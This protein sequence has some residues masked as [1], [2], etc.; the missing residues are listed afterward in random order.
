VLVLRTLLRAYARLFNGGVPSSASVVTAARGGLGV[1]S[2]S[3]AA[4]WP[5]W[6]RYALRASRRFF[7]SSMSFSLAAKRRLIA[8]RS[9][10]AR[11]AR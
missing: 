8:A 4:P 9:F 1:G 3:E 7:R 2:A 5:R 6:V 11:S 10:S